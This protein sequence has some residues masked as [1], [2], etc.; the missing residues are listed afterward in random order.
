MS[1]TKTA[2]STKTATQPKYLPPDAACKLVPKMW[3]GEMKTL[4]ALMGEIPDEA[5][6]EE[7]QDHIEGLRKFTTH[8]STEVP[9]YPEDTEIAIGSKAKPAQESSGPSQVGN[10]MVRWSQRQLEKATIRRD[11]GDKDLLV[12]ADSAPVAVD[13]TGQEESTTQ[14]QEQPELAGELLQGSGGGTE[15]PA[16]TMRV[17]T[18]ACERRAV[19]PAAIAASPPAPQT[20]SREATTT[21]PSASVS[22][23]APLF[24]PSSSTNTP[25][26]ENSHLEGDL[27][28]N[29]QSFA[30]SPSQLLDEAPI[31]E[32]E[33]DQS[34]DEV[35]PEAPRGSVQGED[36]VG[37]HPHG[38]AKARWTPFG[39][40]PHAV[41]QYNACL[42][43]AISTV[44]WA[45]T[46]MAKLHSG[47]GQLGLVIQQAKREI[48]Q[49]QE[50]Q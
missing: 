4:A 48:R 37:S 39:G 45:E 36:D 20:P 35:N 22:H 38:L 46:I 18:E 10:K 21:A 19:P 3:A 43:A 50:W 32:L 25:V 31:G 49:L 41:A 14:P 40:T 7:E 13:A 15:V 12:S 33:G 44:K 11:E 8:M 2:S 1:M 42:A 9:D 17:E 27:Q 28:N 6:E 26:P 5:A 29:P 24:L 30:A 23:P 47:M 16:L 34:G